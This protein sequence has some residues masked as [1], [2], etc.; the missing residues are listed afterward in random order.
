MSTLGD[1]TRSDQF[2]R[3]YHGAITPEDVSRS[4]YAAFHR[5]NYRTR[6]LGS[7]EKVIVQIGTRP[8]AT[9]GGQT[10]ITVTIQSHKDGI[11]VQMGKQNWLG[12]AASL[13]KTALY[14]LRNPLNLIHR[15]DDLAQDIESL[16]LI[17]QIW[18]VVDQTAKAH[19]STQNLS[20]RFRRLVCEYCNTPNLPGE[21]HCVACGAPLGNLQLKTCRF[22][23]YV[24]TAGE[25]K[26][27]NCGKKT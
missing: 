24:L 26:C 21:P 13:G 23:G 6:I 14:A 17:D 15:I 7:G 27:P 5:G 12:V 1:Y 2:Q 11:L 4:L 19:N 16:Q 8:N 22:C 18:R 20:E 10:A 9:S 25:S 3:V